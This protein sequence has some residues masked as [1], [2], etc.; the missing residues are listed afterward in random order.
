[1]ELIVITPPVDINDEISLVK[2]MFKS[3]LYRLHL[4]KE[5]SGIDAYRNYLQQ[6][7]AVFNSQ[8]S[9]HDYP[10]LLKE[11]PGIGFHCKTSVWKD[12]KRLNEVLSF[13]S[14]SIMSASFHSW[15]EMLQVRSD[16]DYAFISPVFNSISKP[17]YPSNIDIT[18][19]KT[20]KQHLNS[21]QKNV[22]KIY[23]LGG[24][25]ATNV[26]K[27]LDAGFDGAAVLGAVWQSDDCLTAFETIYRQ[28]KEFQ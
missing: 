17:G 5:N 4:R 13:S 8:V 24:I 22:P 12:E 16:F 11:F 3:G 15:D 18:K 19:V 20:T 14:S 23:A 1:M 9:V 2:E 21:N 10:E 27:L 7:P 28:L 6:I 26:P 25:D